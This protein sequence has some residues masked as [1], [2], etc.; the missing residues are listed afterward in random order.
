LNT[1]SDSL[2]RR[3]SS[4]TW[5]SPLPTERLPEATAPAASN[6]PPIWYDPAHPACYMEEKLGK[7]FRFFPYNRMTVAGPRGD[8]RVEIPRPR[9]RN[10]GW[11]DQGGDQQLIPHHG[12]DGRSRR[13]NEIHTRNCYVVHKRAAGRVLFVI[14]T[15]SGSIRIASAMLVGGPAQYKTTSPGLAR[16]VPM[17][18]S[19]ARP[20]R[21]FTFGKPPGG[22]KSAWASG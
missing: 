8:L 13:R 22:T 6:A 1:L 5:S 19:A 14:G 15:I 12:P 4:R 9:F 16:I 20:G 10:Y 2:D 7:V 3:R 17:M 21:G 18:K 11:I